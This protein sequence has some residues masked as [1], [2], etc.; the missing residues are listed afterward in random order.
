MSQIIIGTRGSKLA[1]W[2]ARHV[3]TSLRP[4]PEGLQVELKTIKTQG[5]LALEAPLHTMLDKGLF[6]REIESEL[7]DRSIDM[8]VHSLKDLPTELPDGLVI[9][10]ILSREDPSDALVAEAGMTLEN[11]PQG[12]TVLTGSLRRTAQLLHFRDDLKLA[13]VR[14]N[15]ETRLCKLDESDAC[16]MVMASAGL[17]RLGL[18]DRISQRLD[19]MQFL[20]ACGQGAMAV[21]IRAD[22]DVARELLAPLNDRATAAAVSAERAFL[23]A[24][25]GGCQTP[26]GAYGQLADD[27]TLTLTGMVA[28]LDGSKRVADIIEAQVQTVEQ[29]EALGRALA[30]K[31]LAAGGRDILKE[32]A[33][34]S[35]EKSEDGS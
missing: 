6:T 28:S 27:Q 7:L 8:A 11:L 2:Q 4:G 25:G 18:S 29:T 3:S 31:L 35:A 10:A 34:S 1:M 23:A 12:A 20:P 13:N 26:L 21:E 9:G 14:G 22:D 24:L 5:D 32:V 16:A 33:E 19:P 15:V 30:D 17:I